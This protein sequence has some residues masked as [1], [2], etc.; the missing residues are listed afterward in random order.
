MKVALINGQNHRGSTYHIG[1]MLAEKLT[2]SGHISEVFLPKDMQNFC[3]GCF[4]CMLDSESSCPHWQ[5]MKPITALIDSS[6]VLIFISPVYAFHA[7]GSMKALLDHYSYRW[8]SHRP[9]EK[10]F[11]KQGVCVATAAGA[12]AK[13]T[14]KDMR[15]SLTWCGV[16]R[17]YSYGE[18]V[19]AMSWSDITE[20]KMAKIEKK[21][22]RFA[23]TIR[24]RDGRVRPSLKTRIIFNIMRMMQKKPW[25]P[26]DGDY[27]KDKGWMD[28][29]RP[30]KP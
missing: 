29:K 18:G 25:N 7:S 26:A 24:G 10:M 21:T 13:S 28:K 17:V 8:M 4:Q 27:W 9:E 2:D 19:Q 15:D 23:A 5:S 30:W 11:M 1:R 6:D 3:I 12:G 16:G 20:K 14:I 22:D